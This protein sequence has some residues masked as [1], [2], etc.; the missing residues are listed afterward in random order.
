M[1]GLAALREFRDSFGSWLDCRKEMGD[2]E[3]A[4]DKL[5]SVLWS[6]VAVGRRERLAATA[7]LRICATGGLCSRPRHPESG[8][9]AFF[10]RYPRWREE[11]KDIDDT[12]GWDTLQK[13]LGELLTNRRLHPEVMS[14][15]PEEEPLGMWTSACDTRSKKISR[16]G[17]AE[18]S[19]SICLSCGESIQDQKQ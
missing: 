4:E 1:R 16:F 3:P 12:K 10:D 8:Y 2:A 17:M 13:K 14:A 18:S 15:I 19:D 6:P 5:N 9:R 11:Y 7:S